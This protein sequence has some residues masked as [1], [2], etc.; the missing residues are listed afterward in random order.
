MHR[1]GRRGTRV[2]AHRRLSGV[3]PLV[4][5][6]STALLQSFAH[7]E[8]IGL[9]WNSLVSY[10]I[11]VREEREEPPTSRRSVRRSCDE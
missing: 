6:Q 3:V 1:Y 7:N 11:V 2:V 10:R 5:L 8:Y 9:T 4:V